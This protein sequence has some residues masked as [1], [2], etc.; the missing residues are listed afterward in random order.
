MTPMSQI[1]LASASELG[2]AALH[3][4]GMIGDIGVI[5]GWM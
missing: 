3:K 1:M 5:C 2:A 4:P